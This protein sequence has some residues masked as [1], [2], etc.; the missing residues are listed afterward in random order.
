[1]PL[2]PG[3]FASLA[4]RVLEAAD[5]G[6]GVAQALVMQTAHA[7]AVHIVTL[8]RRL[9]FGTPQIPLALGGGLLVASTRVQQELE[10]E[11]AGRGFEFAPVGLAPEP[12]RGAVKLAQLVLGSPGASES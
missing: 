2:R 8:A 9:N 6:D 1:M 4:P 3:D 7:L 11:C 10:E 12:V 5:A